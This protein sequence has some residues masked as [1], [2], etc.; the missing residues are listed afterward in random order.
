M[1]F[2]TI[3][4]RAFLFLVTALLSG[5]ESRASQLNL[6]PE[7]TE[8]IRLMYSGKTN[9]AIAMAH[10]LEAAR[11]EH[12]LGYLIEA[13]VLW[14]KIYCK[15]LE[16]K[17]STIDSWSRQ[18]APDP[19]DDAY[20]ALAD[21]VTHLAEAGIAKSDSAEMELYAGLGYASR[22]RLTGL[23]YEKMATARAGVEARKR[24]L[25]CLEL[26]PDMADANLGLGL[27][28]YYVDTLSGMAKVLRFFMGIPGGDKRVGLRQLGTAATKGEMVQTEA[29]FN[30]AKNLR[31]YDF[32]YARASMAAAPLTSDFPEN[33]LF[34][35]LAGDIAEKLGHK[36]E[37]AVRFRAAAAA[38]M[39]DVKCAERVRQI[40][41]EALTAL[42]ATTK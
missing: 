30:M 24:L 17:Y 13:D 35:L 34:L 32:D 42:G 16:R 23:R 19:D 37:A 6:P 40:V 31:N 29:R 15:L 10:D 33:P 25:R 8:A 12:P 28:N 14:W 5:G 1:R 4:F 2:P 26:D 39:E 36:E 11:P 41:S 7:A 3:H 21:K 22:A 18:R 9:Q 38:P 27:Y 20:L